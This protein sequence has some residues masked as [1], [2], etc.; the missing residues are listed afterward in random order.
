MIS[1]DS[2]K[3]FTRPDGQ[4]VDLTYGITTGLLDSMTIPTG[5]YEY[6][7]DPTSA[8]LTTITAP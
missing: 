6:S 4:T 7:Y 2:H 3:F 8:Q 1:I 5:T